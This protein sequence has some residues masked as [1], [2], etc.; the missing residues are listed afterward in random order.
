MASNR[1]LKDITLSEKVDLLSV[2]AERLFYRL[3][4]KADDFGG[5]FAHPKI[6]KS[7]CFPLKADTI[8]DADISHWID[9][10]V[11]AGIII[12]YTVADKPYLRI[13]DFGQRLRT[14]R[15]KFPDPP[16]EM[17]PATTDSNPL[18]IVSNS[19]QGAADGG[20]LSLKL[21]EKLEEKYEGNTSP[22][23]FSSDN[24]FP[25]GNG[26]A[27]FVISDKL[28]LPVR[29]REAVEL[30]QFTFTQN[31]NSDFVSAHWKLFIVEA[32]STPNKRYLSMEEFA[33][34]F[35]NWMRTKFPKKDHNDRP[36]TSTGQPSAAEKK[37]N[38]ILGIQ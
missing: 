8:R 24:D 33:S 14:K 12:V 16:A 31:K 38:S 4:M 18:T 20:N 34:H 32:M 9:E 11:K 21:E 35:R 30:N 3:I 7:N 19:P 1:L 36:E 28:E 26:F 25:P 10:L 2:H 23:S 15:S 22:S 27:P 29:T 6:V 17:I 13:L 5:F 37:A